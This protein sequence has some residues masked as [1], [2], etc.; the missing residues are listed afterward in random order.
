M[1]SKIISAQ[2]EVYRENFINYGDTP[3]GTF[4]NNY[5]TQF[6]RHE[7]LLRHFDI[8]NMFSLHDVGSGVCDL[9]NYLI[10]NNIKHHYTGTEI[11]PEMIE[12]SKKKFPEI[13]VFNRDIINDKNIEKC[14]IVTSSGMLNLAGKVKENE[15][16]DFLFQLMKK[17]FELSN[18]GIS[19]NFLTT[20]KTLNDKSLSYFNP[21]E[22]FDFA[23]RNLSRFVLLDHAY[24]LYEGTIAIF[25]EEYIKACYSEQAFKKYFRK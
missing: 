23:V 15:W 19:F 20:H 6:L 13:N 1:K 4:Q 8:S 7:R 25:H 22:L 21:G 18:W 14:D 12:L 11:V 24:P 2:L 17:M 3:E 10:K 5:E 9:H 16:K